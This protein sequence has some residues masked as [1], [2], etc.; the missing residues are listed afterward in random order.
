MDSVELTIFK[1]TQ[2]DTLSHESD[3]LKPFS[4]L[5]KVCRQKY[6]KIFKFKKF[7]KLKN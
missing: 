3:N 4:E 1:I 5:L 2:N 7:K 6:K